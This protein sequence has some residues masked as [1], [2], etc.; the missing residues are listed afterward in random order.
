M[1]L[2]LALVG[3]ASSAL[4][5]CTS[6]TSSDKATEADYDDIAQ[7]LS[8]VVA[9]NG[10]G[11]DLISLQDSV[12]IALGAPSLGITVNA[13]GDFIGTR[14]GLNYDYKASCSDAS[15]AAQTHCDATTDAAAVDVNWSGKLELPNLTASVQREGTW[16]LSKIQ[17]GTVALDGSGD[18]DVDLEF[19]SL[20][21]DVTR[22]YHLSYSADYQDVQLQ[23]LPLQVTNG[24]I[25]YVID[26]ERKASG[27]RH[28][29]DANFH[30][31]GTLQFAADGSATLTLDGMFRYAIDPGS[32]NMTKL[33]NASVNVSVSV[34]GK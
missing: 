14:L 20:F 23:L 1:K 11:G 9:T 6:S 26:A 15:G 5:G 31:E 22:D 4:L 32:G 18:F 29:S 3:L 30:V 21:R 13:A 16:K 24:S 7:S 25:K 12:S 17:S 2:S 10:S 8:S 33:S 28:E 27:V 19:Q 34:N